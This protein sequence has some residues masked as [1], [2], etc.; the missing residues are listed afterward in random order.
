MQTVLT[1][2]PMTGRRDRPVVTFSLCTFTMCI[3]CMSCEDHPHEYHFDLDGANK[4]S[5]LEH[6]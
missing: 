6:A 4:V 2:W 3:G 1:G 5:L